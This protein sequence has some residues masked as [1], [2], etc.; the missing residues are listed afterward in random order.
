MR[1]LALRSTQ[2]RPL[3]P[4]PKESLIASA[5]HI[6]AFDDT[7]TAAES[8][9]RASTEPG[10]LQRGGARGESAWQDEVAQQ[11]ALEV[12]TLQPHEAITRTPRSCDGPTA[13]PPFLPGL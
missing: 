9:T 2:P 7:P 12:V 4:N 11:D 5:L 8:L 10:Q 1:H 3:T 6:K 13:A